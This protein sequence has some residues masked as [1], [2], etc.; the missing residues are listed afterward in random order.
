MTL[1]VGR[2]RDV[3][4]PEPLV[5]V[6]GGSEQ[7]V[8]FPPWTIHNG[9]FGPLVSRPGRLNRSSTPGQMQ[10]CRLQS[11]EGWGWQQGSWKT[12]GHY[13]TSRVQRGHGHSS[14]GK[15]LKGSAKAHRSLLAGADFRGRGRQEDG[16]RCWEEVSLAWCGGFEGWG[17]VGE[18]HCHHRCGPWKLPA[19]PSPTLVGH[20][21][22]FCLGRGELQDVRHT[23]GAQ[24]S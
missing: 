20:W 14:E 10:G 1:P 9:N 18:P 2:K 21:S 22:D 19:A 4:Q 13:Y 15:I 23:S 6:V 17:L 8:N 12:D 3:R 5:V 11:F 16:P 24:G 7:R